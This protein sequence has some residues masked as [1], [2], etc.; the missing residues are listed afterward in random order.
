MPF[1]W[2][3][4]G[5]PVPLRCSAVS[6]F[7]LYSARRRDYCLRFPFL[8]AGVLLLF[9]LGLVACLADSLP[10]FLA[11]HSY[12][13]LTPFPVQ[14]LAN[15]T[16]PLTLAHA[17]VLWKKTEHLRLRGANTSGA[18]RRAVT[19]GRRDARA[20]TR[21]RW[22]GETV[23][24]HVPFLSFPSPPFFSFFLSPVFFCFVVCSFSKYQNADVPGTLQADAYV[25][26]NRAPRG[27]VADERDECGPPRGA[28]RVRHAVPCASR[29]WRTPRACSTMRLGMRSGRRH[30]GDATRSWASLGHG[31]LA[32]GRRRSTQNA[33]RVSRQRRR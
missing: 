16:C 12:Y 1:V 28:R 31:R 3:A 29:A 13:S 23:E 19:G 11:F 6:C 5:V 26:A 32:V 33:N 20:R 9:L 15:A 10:P 17:A 18:Q 4:A 7:M 8:H 14:P 25:K 21:G 22:A 27:G 30:L 2:C 24:G